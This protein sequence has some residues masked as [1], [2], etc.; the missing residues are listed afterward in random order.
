MGEAKKQWPDD[1]VKRI[2]VTLGPTD[3]TIDDIMKIT[4]MSTGALGSIIAQTLMARASA[5]KPV[6]L[7]LVC[8]K[9]AY[10]INRPALD[11]LI[12]RG[13]H[14]VLI[15]GVKHGVRVTS[16]AQDMLDELEKLY[17]NHKIDYLFHSAAVGDYVGRYASSARML[18]D[19]IY[20][21]YRQAGAEGFNAEAIADVLRAPK[22]V[23]DRDTKM[24]SDEPDMLVKLGLTPKVIARITGLAKAAGYETKMISWKLLSG[25][26]EAELLD[27][28]LQ[29]GKRNGSYLVVAND[30]A[31]IND[32]GHKAIILNVA[33][34]EKVVATTKQD[35]ANKLAD[36]VGL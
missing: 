33:S 6:E 36:A 5:E 8:N 23:F 35:I 2:V 11:G 16:E 30:L 4:N 17:Q 7:F 20:A 34:G 28:A 27:V 31:Q 32:G 29:H 9:T 26:S 15:G 12:A 19:E 24:S 13:A 21:L 25:V 18:A 3:E 14:L 1:G 22:S 10:L